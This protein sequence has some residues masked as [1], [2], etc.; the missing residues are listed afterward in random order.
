[1]ARLS[2]MQED[3]AK[4]QSELADLVAK[5]LFVPLA[6]ISAESG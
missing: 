5:K 2:K 1:M 4:A 6:V 3:M